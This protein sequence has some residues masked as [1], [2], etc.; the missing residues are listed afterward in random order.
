L[1]SDKFGHSVGVDGDI[2]VAGANNH[3]HPGNDTGTV[4]VYERDLG[5]AGNYG[6]RTELLSPTALNNDQF[7]YSLGI[8]REKLVVG[9]PFSGLDNQSKYGAAFAYSRHTGGVDNWGLLQKLERS[10]AANND[11]FGIAAG[12]GQDTA[13]V[14][15]S[16]TDVAGNDSGSV[17][18]YRL[19]YGN[20]PQ[21]ATPIP[22]QEADV[23]VP[24][25]YT[26][27][28]EIFGD[29]DV[30]DTLSFAATLTDNSPLPAWLS[31]NPVPG[32]FSGT[33]P[34]AGTYLIRVRATDQDGL[35]VTD[36][37]SLMISGS[38]LR[39]GPVAPPLH[40]TVARDISTS[41]VLVTY[42]R[43]LN[44][45]PS[46]YILESSADLL[47]WS[48]SNPTVLGTTITGLDI[49]TERVTVRVNPTTSRPIEFFRI[50]IP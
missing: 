38:T 21:L 14:G 7:G 10:D 3:D 41:E 17:Y 43:P 28:P 19:K 25:T 15:A 33:P 44:A 11:Q 9:A 32:T 31:F 49:L 23:N 48:S 22:D 16:M 27:G 1:G 18:I 4:Y 34:V 39:I 13:V 2:A 26:I 50:R 29:P 6:L 36:D 24:F 35:S 20:A 46:D 45:V 40:L 47:T 12:I 37:F 30:T 5:G 42:E 8:S